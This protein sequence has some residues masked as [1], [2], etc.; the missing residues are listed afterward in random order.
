[1]SGPASTRD[2]GLIRVQGQLGRTTGPGLRAQIQARL[3]QGQRS[4]RLDLSAVD[5][6]D[7]SGL[8]LLVSLRKWASR[9]G[10]ELRLERPSAPVT[11]L[12]R[13]TRLD[14]FLCPE[15]DAPTG[16]V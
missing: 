12:L 16:T 10:F 1:V 3:G 8:G 5:F 13:M 6:A 4:I 15:A 2:E 14:R 9:E 11:R 7:S